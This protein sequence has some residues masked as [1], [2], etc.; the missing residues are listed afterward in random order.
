MLNKIKP[1]QGY[2]PG[3]P[4]G[5]ALPADRVHPHLVVQGELAESWDVLGPLDKHQQLLFHR[6][7]H[8]RD[9]GDLLCP[10]VTI[11][12][13][14]RGGDLGEKKE[15]AGDGRALLIFSVPCTEPPPQRVLLSGKGELDCGCLLSSEGSSGKTGK[16]G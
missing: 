2:I 10:N 1:V 3:G 15:N 16:G 12:S 11:D 9:A 13:R 4:A 6:L 8:I 14:D 5:P 7:T